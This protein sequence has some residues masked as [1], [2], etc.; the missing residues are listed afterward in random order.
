MTTTLL[1]TKLHR[2]TLRPDLIPRARLRERLCAG[3][4]SGQTFSRKLTLVAAPAGF[5]KTTL[6]LDFGF[7]ISET[8]PPESKIENL[9]SGWLS[10]DEA[11]NDPVRFLH[12]LIAALQRDVPD[13][14]RDALALL[15]AG[16]TSVLDEALTMVINEIAATPVPLLLVLDDYHVLHASAIERLMTFLLD[17][18]PANLHLVIASRTDPALPLTRLRARGHLLELRARDLRFTEDEA[19]AFLSETMGLALRPEWI[20]ALEQRT[21]GWIA[22]LQLAALSLQGHTD[23]ANFIQAFSGS[24]RYVIDY[25]VDEVLRHQPPSV[26]DFLVQTALLE[27]LC[28]PLCDAI[29]NST[30]SQAMLEHLERANLFLIPLD[31]QR[32]WY[33]YHHLFADSLRAELDVSQQTALRRGAAVWFAEH[34][35]P[36]EAVQHARATGDLTFMAEMIERALQQP[37]AWS[38]G[39]L[40]TLVGWLDALPAALLDARPALSLYASRALY[41]CGRIVE[42]EQLIERAVRSLRGR[43]DEDAGALLALADIY[44]GAIAVI[45]GMAQQAIEWVHQGLA[46]LPETALHTRARAFD[47]LAT[48]CHYTGDA[49]QAEHYFLQASAVAETAKVAYLAINARCEA[50]QMQMLQGRL[51]EAGQTCREAL[52]LSAVPIPP[53][54]LA[55]M[56]L[57]EI[58]REQNDLATAEQHFR[59]G[60]ALAQQ[61]GLTD[62]VLAILVSQAQLKQNQGDPDGARQLFGQAMRILRAY[63]TERLTQQ[64][65]VQ[66]ARFDLAQECLEAAVQWARVYEQARAAQTVEYRRDFEDLT[67]ARVLLATGKTRNARTV[68][69]P[70]AARAQADGRIR[71]L[72]EAHLLITLAHHREGNDAEA[73]GVL[74]QAVT[75]AA[76]ERWLR[77]FLDAN[78]FDG[79]LAALLPRA[80]AAAP[81]FVDELRA[82]LGESARASTSPVDDAVLVPTTGE[83]IS[84]REVEILHLLAEGLSNREIGQAL[85]IGVGTV[86]WYLTHLYDKLDV[87]NRTQAVT[88]AREFGLI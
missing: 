55:W 53:Q 62:D 71:H 10:L 22:G 63:Q 29:T 88:R 67:L 83:S 21:E 5:G 43:D 28:G 3:L 33:R 69:D 27:R 64:G 86:K 19:A 49:R 56:I 1:Q 7:W 77:L 40:A 12:Y 74:R 80:R 9:K 58:A 50:A 46:L 4:W 78:D 65:L 24:H 72:L 76:P 85:Y 26:R 73:V 37:S 41:L 35:L 60:L 16:V 51:T 70:V 34:A 31:D 13:L 45:R 25:L 68:L 52:Q 66:Q 32:Q 8:V 11:D 20:A 47:I 87:P 36:V 15:E 59:Q 18:Q 17:H 82:V 6:I 75:V 30:N 44:Q 57:G 42:S 39:Q 23:P 14:G 81:D 79:A 48:A 2:P 54:G 38:G 84:A 61:G